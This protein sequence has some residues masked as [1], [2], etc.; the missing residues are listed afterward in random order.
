VKDLRLGPLRRRAWKLRRKIFPEE[1]AIGMF[2][3]PSPLTLAPMRG[4][5]S[6]ILTRESV[7]DVDATF[8]ADPFLVRE[9]GQWHLF[10]EV[11]HGPAG[12]RK[13]DIALATSFDARTWQYRG[14][15]LREPFH[16]SYPYVF[17]A[18]PDHYMV[19]ES[20]QAGEVRLYRAD[21]FP[22]RWTLAG[23]L[24]SGPVHLDNCVFEHEGRWWMLTQTDEERGTLRLFVAD[25]VTGPWREHPASPVVRH[26]LRTGRGAGRVTR[27]DGRLVRFAQDCGGAYG[28]S[29]GALEIVR[30]DERGYEEREL[31]E[32]PILSG[33][34][35][36][37]N[38]GGMHHVDPHQLEDGTWIACVDGWAA[39]LRPPRELA[40]LCA[41]RMRARLR[42]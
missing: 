25:A 29:V 19:P 30:L 26:D 31:P 16:L 37:W 10:F 40:A 15:V 21:P 20:T 36:G 8:V 38:A 1:F 5:M 32:S 3:G 9:R 11:L 6:P 28:T 27:F 7:S 22:H 23:T 24:L 13:G 41:A 34:G 4:A 17:R 2:A 42:R 12:A 33:S 39:H 35:A 14:I 18:G